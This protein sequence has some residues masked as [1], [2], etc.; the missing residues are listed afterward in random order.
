MMQGMSTWFVVGALLFEAALL[1]SL[2]EVC[3]LW[4]GRASRYDVVPL[5]R[6]RAVPVRIGAGLVWIP[7]VLATGA[8]GATEDATTLST[9]LV[10]ATLLWLLLACLLVVTVSWLGRPVRLVPRHLRR[11]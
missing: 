7:L 9:V 11:R 5:R 3:K 4:R 2:V 1:L 6:R 8:T 10:A